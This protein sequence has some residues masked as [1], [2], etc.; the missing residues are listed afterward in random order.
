MPVFLLFC[1]FF[2]ENS[3]FLRF[4]WTKWQWKCA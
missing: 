1:Y 2:L 4:N 3:D